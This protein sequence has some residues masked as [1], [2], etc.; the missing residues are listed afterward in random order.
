MEGSDKYKYFI[1][2]LVFLLILTGCNENSN[3]SSNSTNSSNLKVPIVNDN[4]FQEIGK[5]IGLDFTHSIG[6]EKMENIVESV[7]GGAAFLDFDQDGFMDIFTC[8]GT[9]VEG[10]SKG[11][12]PKK[13]PENHLYRNKQNGTFEDVSKKSR[14]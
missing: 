9:W 14:N 3:K 2:L 13:L 12:K 7:G 8:S 5:E 11:E 10:F 4:F 6:A 1:F